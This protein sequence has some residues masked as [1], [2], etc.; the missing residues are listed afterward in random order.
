MSVVTKFSIRGA[1]WLDFLKFLDWK[2]WIFQE[3]KDQISFCANLEYKKWN[4]MGD[5]IKIV[6]FSF[7]SFLATIVEICSALFESFKI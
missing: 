5:F 7:F 3:E 4:M 1:T 6:P 2:D